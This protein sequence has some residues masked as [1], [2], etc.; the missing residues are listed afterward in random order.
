MS[1]NRNV[2]SL[3]KGQKPEAGKDKLSERLHKALAN[4]GLGS[5]RMLEKRIQGGEVQLNGETAELGNS[6]CSGDRVELDGRQYVVATDHREHARVIAYNKPDGLLTTRDDPEGRPTVFDELRDPPGGRWISVGRLDINTS[7]LLLLTTDGELANALM[8]PANEVEREYLCRVQ[9]ELPDDAINKLT[10]GIEL[11]DGKARFEQIIAIDSDSSHAWYRVVLREGRNREVRR[12]WQA[13]GCEVS[14]L[15][16]IR[17]G[18]IS[19]PRRLKRGEHLDLDAADINRLRQLANIGEP[20]AT[21][22]LKPVS[23][24]RRVRRSQTEIKPSKQTPSAWT[25]SYNDE[26]R[27]LSA[28]DRARPES[29]GRRGRPGGGR[30]RAAGKEVNGNLLQPDKPAGKK[31]RKSRRKAAPGQELPSVRSWF[32]G[33]DRPGSKKSGP[34]RGKGGN[35]NSNRG[36]GNRGN[37]KPGGN[38]DR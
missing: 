28:W 27:E 25:G 30:K 31:R 22:T 17:Y 18:C 36:G 12:M 19:L 33:D 6:V 16:R 32:A 3:N 21:L 14:R 10:R 38:R 7:G 2:L 1:A 8:H 13:V 15:K 9:G 4:A 23:H 11:E 24:Q 29:T 37:R 35:Q 20:S 5:R 34:R 26:R